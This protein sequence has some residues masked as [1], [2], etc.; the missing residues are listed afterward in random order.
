MKSYEKLSDTEK[1]Q[2]DNFATIINGYYLNATNSEFGISAVEDQLG[3]SEFEKK[4]GKM[5]M[6]LVPFILNNRYDSIDNILKERAFFYEIV[7]AQ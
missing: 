2:F 1:T 6:G 7:G 3:D 5:M 4:D